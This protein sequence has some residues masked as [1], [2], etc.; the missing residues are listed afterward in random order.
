MQ[1]N[2]KN[3]LPLGNSKLMS[4]IVALSKIGTHR[5]RKLKRVF[6]QGGDKRTGDPKQ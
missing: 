3:Q 5:A 4:I 1:P 6:A 2:F